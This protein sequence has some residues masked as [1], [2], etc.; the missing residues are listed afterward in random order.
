MFMCGR[1]YCKVSSVTH[2]VIW[3]PFRLSMGGVISSLPVETTR[4]RPST[5]LARCVHDFD[6]DDALPFTPFKHQCTLELSPTLEGPSFATGLEEVCDT[7]PETGAGAFFKAEWPKVIEN[8]QVLAGLVSALSSGVTLLKDYVNE[9]SEESQ[10][11]LARFRVDLGKRTDAAGARSIFELLDHLIHQQDKGEL[12]LP[13]SLKVQLKMDIQ[14]SL[15]Q[16]IFTQL[17]E[18]LQPVVS[19]V[20]SWSSGQHGREPGDHLES[21]MKDVRDRLKQLEDGV[22]ALH[23]VTGQTLRRSNQVP[24]LSFGFGAPSASPGVSPPVA[25]PPHNGRRRRLE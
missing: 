23:G 17:Q 24:T 11:A 1:Q 25:S 16:E 10:D 6:D 21:A 5:R 15:L 9:R 13:D 2:T 12:E 7:I 8:I 22:L 4:L 18:Q 3:I 19:F 20:A 14:N